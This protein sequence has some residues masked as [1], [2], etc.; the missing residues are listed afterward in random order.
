MLNA[1]V[2]NLFIITGRMNC[3]LTLAGRKINEFYPKIL[4]LSNN[5]E[6]CL[7][8]TQCLS[9]CLSWSFV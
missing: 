9:T 4:P 6:E 1:S 8:L 2:G 3:A 7:L 5:E